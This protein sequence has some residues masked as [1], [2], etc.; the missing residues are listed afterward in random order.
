VIDGQ[1]VETFTGS[2]ARVGSGTLTW[3]TKFHAAFDCTTQTLSNLH[4]TGTI[5]SGT[6]ALARLR[7]T[8]IFTDEKYSGTLRNRRVCRVRHHRKH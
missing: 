3:E 6:G 8:L 7:G 1:G 2:V 4:G 5:M